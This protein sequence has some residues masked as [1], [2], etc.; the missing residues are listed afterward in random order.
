MLAMSS[1]SRGGIVIAEF[2]I[3]DA[4]FIIFNAEF[5]ICDAKLIIFNAQLI[6]FNAEFIICGAKLII[7]NTEFQ[8]LFRI[9]VQRYCRDE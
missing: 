3:C 2:I 4:K 1:L 5:I 7:S 8:E 6:I 9:P